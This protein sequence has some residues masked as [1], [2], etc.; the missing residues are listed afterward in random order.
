MKSEN[1]VTHI[2]PSDGNVFEDLGFDADEAIALQHRSQ[3][4]I[5]EKMAIKGISLDV[6][7][8]RRPIPNS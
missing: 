2:T 8:I 4:I 1:G 5:N 7:G 3:K 6:D